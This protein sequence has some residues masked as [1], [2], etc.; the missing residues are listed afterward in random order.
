MEKLHPP[1]AAN[2]MRTDSSRQAKFGRMWTNVGRSQFHLPMN[3]PQ[4]LR[5]HVS[6]VPPDPEAHVAG[7]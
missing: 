5:G 4:V 3:K 6:A 2:H 1:F 7:K